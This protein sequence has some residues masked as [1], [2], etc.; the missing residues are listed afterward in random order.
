MTPPELVSEKKNIRKFDTENIEGH[1]S[2]IST[3]KGLY[4]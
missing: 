2:L 1:F 3:Y 4:G